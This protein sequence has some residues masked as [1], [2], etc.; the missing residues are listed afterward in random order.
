MI[1]RDEELEIPDRLTRLANRI[2]LLSFA[3]AF[4]FV[5]GILAAAKLG[6]GDAH[7][8]VRAASMAPLAFAL[9]LALR[10][11]RLRAELGRELGRA[12]ARPQPDRAGSPAA[13]RGVRTVTAPVRD[14]A[15][16]RKT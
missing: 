11:R 3:F 8:I 6:G 5:A 12:K 15:A 4:V 16:A 2:A 1:S 7:V 10:V 13:R 9:V 14:A